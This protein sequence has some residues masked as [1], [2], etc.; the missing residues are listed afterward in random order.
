MEELHDIT[1]TETQQIE[2]QTITLTPDEI[3]SMLQDG[4]FPAVSYNQEKFLPPV[5]NLNVEW[6][7]T[8]GKVSGITLSR[9]IALDK[10]NP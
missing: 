2:Q 3:S 7:V 6:H 4:Y 9:T 8:D 1:S 5:V 10:T